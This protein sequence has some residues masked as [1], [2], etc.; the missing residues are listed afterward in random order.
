M[1][2]DMPSKI[3]VNWT[4]G[5]HHDSSEKFDMTPDV[6]EQS[7]DINFQQIQTFFREKDGTV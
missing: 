2:V 1:K 5:S 7:I 6:S 3:Q 4:S